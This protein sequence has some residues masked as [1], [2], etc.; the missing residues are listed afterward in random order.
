ML[1]S[2]VKYRKMESE[3]V[4]ARLAPDRYPISRGSL[5]AFRVWLSWIEFAVS[6]EVFVFRAKGVE[7]RKVLTGFLGLAI[8]LA[9]AAGLFAQSLSDYQVSGSIAP[10]YQGSFHEVY[11]DSGYYG[12]GY[13]GGYIGGSYTVE[14]ATPLFGRYSLRDRISR[15]RTYPGGLAPYAQYGGFFGFIVPGPRG[16]ENPYQGIDPES[17]N[18]Y[19]GYTVTRGPRDFLMRN[20]PNIGP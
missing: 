6:G 4:S 15:Y 7:M 20:P 13:S 8:T 3:A 11:Y 17:N 2:R 12:G 5:L 18:P 19:A 9:S 14:P 1:V 16:N 10:S